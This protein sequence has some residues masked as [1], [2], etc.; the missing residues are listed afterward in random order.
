MKPI[1]IRNEY[2]ET[3]DVK[4]DSD[5]SIFIRHSDIDKKNF[6]QLREYDKQARNPKIAKALKDAGVDIEDPVAKELLPKMGSYMAIGEKI[7]V[8]NA[9]ETA[10]IIDTVRLNGGIVPNWSSLG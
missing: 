9:R 4:W 2:G 3:I 6:G 10:L 8:V 5:G 1:T 7:Y